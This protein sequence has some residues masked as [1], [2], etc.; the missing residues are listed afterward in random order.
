[1]QPLLS[2][3]SQRHEHFTLL[4]NISCSWLLGMASVMDGWLDDGYKTDEW[5]HLSLNN[6]VG[7]F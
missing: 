6:F 3:S 7:I 2:P 1:M 5:I 4:L